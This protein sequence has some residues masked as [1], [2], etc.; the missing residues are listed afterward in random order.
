MVHSPGMAKPTQTD[1]QFKLR[2]PADLKNRIEEAAESGNR[3]MNAEIIARLEG[4]ML[5]DPEDQIRSVNRLL[6][7]TGSMQ[8]AIELLSRRIDHLHQELAKSYK[9]TLSRRTKNKGDT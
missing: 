2:L 1:P 4:S 6:D 5:D 8:R 3:S 7:S 9:R